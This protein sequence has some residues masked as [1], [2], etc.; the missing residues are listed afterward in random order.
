MPDQIRIDMACNNPDN[1]NFVGCVAQIQLP[2]G[3]L[4]LTAKAWNITS[5]H[6]CPKLDE[7]R[8]KIVLSGKAWP[9][10]RS[11]DWFG[12]WCWN[13]YWFD[14][15]VALRFLR[16]LH[17][18]NLFMLEGGWSDLC[19]LWQNPSVPITLDEAWRVRLVEE[20]RHE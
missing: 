19:E 9:I 3:A 7:S 18:R 16:W 20:S 11:I 13:A 5:F 6:R 14:S 8:S 1:G 12:N 2:N 10:V 15:L 4:E 17:A